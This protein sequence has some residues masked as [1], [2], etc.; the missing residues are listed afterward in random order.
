M[1]RRFPLPRLHFVLGGLCA[2][3][4]R[5]NIMAAIIGTAVGN[6]W[7]FPF[8]WTLIYNLGLWMGAGGGG[9]D[10]SELEFSQ[11]F[12]RSMDAMLT[13]DLVYLFETAWPVLWPM[14]IGGIPA[15][16]VSWA[17]FFFP[18]RPLVRSYQSKRR[19]KMMQKLAKRKPQNLQETKP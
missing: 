18:L 11:I 3:V 14:F 4:M 12:S 1:G 19:K 13:F 7:T 17:F 10:A 8:I 9:G 2:W 15:F 6:P 16:F 5:A